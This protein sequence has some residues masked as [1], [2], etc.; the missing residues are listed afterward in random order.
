MSANG[1]HFGLGKLDEIFTQERD[2]TGLNFGS[3]GQQLHDRQRRNAFAGA[4][5]ADDA[6]R[7]PPLDPERN[8]VHRSY[9]TFFGVEVGAK[10]L[11]INNSLSHDSFARE[12]RE[13]ARIEVDAI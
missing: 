1:P 10:V 8:I 11:N 13:W 5:F 4:T 7:V 2:G 12:S 9:G 3:R 6:K